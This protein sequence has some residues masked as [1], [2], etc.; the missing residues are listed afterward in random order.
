[1]ASTTSTDRLRRTV[2]GT[3]HTGV[4]AGI[5]SVIPM[6][7]YDTVWLGNELFPAFGLVPFAVLWGVLYAGL[8]SIDRIQRLAATPR[9]GVPLGVAYSALVWMGPQV[10]EPIGQGTFTVNGA[11]QV[12]LFGAVL[13][14]VYAYSP[15]VG[16]E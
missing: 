11:V 8:A 6:I 3:W 10:G 2:I 15:D 9:T 4:G 13:G 12:V 16:V 14:L 5:A 7:L 1:M